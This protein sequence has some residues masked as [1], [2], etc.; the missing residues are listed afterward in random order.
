MALIKISTVKGIR[1]IKPNE[2]VNP[3]FPDPEI[4]IEK[5]EELF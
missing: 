3:E 2:V 4:E 5:D 1:E